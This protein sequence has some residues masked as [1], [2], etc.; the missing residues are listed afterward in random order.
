M[1]EIDRTFSWSGYLDDLT[2]LY[3]MFI[4]KHELPS[5]S[6]DEHDWDTI[7]PNQRRWLDEF[8]AAWEAEEDDLSQR[9][10]RQEK[11]LAE[12]VLLNRLWLESLSA[13]R[14][15]EELTNGEEI[16]K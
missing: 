7:T 2:E 16:A 4:K 12:L 10:D 5:V 15:A 1:L 8:S 14:E 9:A 11:Q 13:V 3:D 6:A